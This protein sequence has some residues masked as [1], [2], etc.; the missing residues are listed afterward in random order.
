MVYPGTMGAYHVTIS[1]DGSALAEIDVSHH[2]HRGRWRWQSVPRPIRKSL[3]QL[4]AARLLPHFDDSVLGKPNNARMLHLVYTPMSYPN[5]SKLMGSSGV[6]DSIGLVT[7]MQAT[8]LFGKGEVD[9]MFA[10][11]EASGTV[12]WH[13]RDETTG[14]PTDMST[15]GN[16]PLYTY[17]ASTDPNYVAVPACEIAVDSGHTPQLTYVPFLLT[18]DP[19][20]LEETQF[21]A[22]FEAIGQLPGPTGSGHFRG[23]GRYFAWPLRNALFAWAATPSAVPSWLLPKNY[24]DWMVKQW[25]GVFDQTAMNNAADAVCTLW[26][27]MPEAI[28]PSPGSPGGSAFPNPTFATGPR[29]REFWAC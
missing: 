18:G 14:A 27:A 7:E 15:P 5:L 17:I 10:Q 16:I 28:N 29:F 3:A 23:A 19:Y 6:P 20:Y 13:I 12:P 21:E 24:F 22:T 9:S 2:N 4:T 8:A 26:H 11:A 1:Q 25:G